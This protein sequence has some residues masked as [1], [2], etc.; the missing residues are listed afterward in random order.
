MA[1]AQALKK[2]ISPSAVL[3]QILDDQVT[4]ILIF[5]FTPNRVLSI[6]R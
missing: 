2:V 3:F 5:F 1:T 4:S 6:E